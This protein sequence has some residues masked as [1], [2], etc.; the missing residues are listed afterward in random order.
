[1]DILA[2]LL[3]LTN[4]TTTPTPHHPA[5]HSNNTVKPE[6]QLLWLVS[7]LWH[8][9]L[10]LQH[11][12]ASPG[13]QGYCNCICDLVD[14]TLQPAAGVCVKHD[15]LCI[16]CT[17]NLQQEVVWTVPTAA[18]EGAV[19]AGHVSG[20]GQHDAEEGTCLQLSDQER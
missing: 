17:H 11:H 18:A 16:C 1:M 10:L 4:L 2:L 13:S 12:I 15:L 7:Y 6:Q 9:E 3:L 20:D 5:M 8:T 19:S 14:T